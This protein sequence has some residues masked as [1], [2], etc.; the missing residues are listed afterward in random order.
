M[1]DMR[2]QIELKLIGTQISDWCKHREGVIFRT[3]LCTQERCIRFTTPLMQEIFPETDTAGGVWKSGVF[4]MYEIYNGVDEFKITASVSLQGLPK[5]Q[6]KECLELLNSCGIDSEERKG[7]YFLKEWS[8]PNTARDLPKI[9]D[10]INE[11]SEFEMSYFETELAK[12]KDNH[13]YAIKAFPDVQLG[14]LDRA[15]LPEELLIEGGMKDIL[16]NRYERNIT[17]RK[18]C[19]AFHG[20]ACN[21]CGFDFGTTYGPE[22]AGKIHVH[23]K[24]PLFEI[25]EDYVVDPIEDLVPVC[26]NCHLILHSKPDGFY[27]VD[28]VKEMRER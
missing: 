9:M 1:D 6:K 19:I 28:E 27:T 24:L 8:Y 25:K 15:D 4:F 14:I 22:F 26:P 13:T 23:H 7:M 3:A 11:F 12:W 17:A 10:A 16:T 20:T 5:K 2:S 21:I 18:K